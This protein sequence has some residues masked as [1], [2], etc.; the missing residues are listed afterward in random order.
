MP[1][2]DPGSKEGWP[3]KIDTKVMVNRVRLFKKRNLIW[4]AMA[5]AAVLAGIVTLVSWPEPLDHY[6]PADSLG[7]LE[8][9]DGSRVIDLIHDRQ[10][11]EQAF[12]SEKAGRI[13]GRID[14]TIQR[15]GITQRQASALQAALIFTSVSVEP[16]QAIKIHGVLLVR[17]R[18]FWIRN[19]N[20]SPRS[21]AEMSSDAHSFVSMERLRGKEIATITYSKPGQIIFVA[22]HR[23]CVL[24]SNQQE[25][26][27]SILATLDGVEPSITTTA[28]WKE[29]PPRFQKASMVRGFFKG[30]A[31]FDLL[32]DY[33]VKNYSAFDDAARTSRFLAS[34]GLDQIR[35][36]TYNAQMQSPGVSESWHFRASAGS[37]YT[38]SFVSLF[39]NQEGSAMDSFS[40]AWLPPNAMSAQ[41]ITTT[42]MQEMWNAFANSLAI[43]TSQETS[44][45]R[46]LVI[47]VFEG[48]LGF[49]IQRDLLANL[50]SPIVFF[51]VSASDSRLNAGQAIL[52]SENQEGW[53]FAA[54]T[55]NRPTLESVFSKIIAEERTPNRI[56]VDDFIVFY[57][58]PGHGAAKTVRGLLEGI[59]AF[60]A[61]DDVIY[62]SPEKDILVSSLRALRN[63]LQ[64]PQYNLPAQFHPKAPFLSLSP[65]FQKKRSDQEEQQA[66]KEALL[67]PFT[68]SEITPDADGFQFH[69]ISSCG[70]VCDFMRRVVEASQ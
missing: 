50:S 63:S 23:D 58:N 18:S 70:F 4:A 66:S 11:L 27:A 9:Q 48:A 69:R 14:A 2:L 40:Q 59:P 5:A 26:L 45:N 51:Q 36:L 43:L 52:E 39:V 31:L 67:C 16:D 13:R 49:R 57:S 32:R 15:M 20:L 6:I 47:A 62:F 38:Q 21:I 3:N 44:Q 17:V 25:A 53:V 22:V 30:P 68:I 46:S 8:I 34:M 24:F 54:R 55:Q 10:F 61:K 7:F 64:R 37:A 60:A 56:A 65:P 19:L 29:A 35:S 12:N 28:V 33:L 42:K 41:F 1:E